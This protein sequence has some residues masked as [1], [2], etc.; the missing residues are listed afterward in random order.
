MSPTLDICGWAH[1][2]PIHSSNI[3][4]T[5]LPAGPDDTDLKLA[6]GVGVGLT[7]AD[8][9]SVCGV[10]EG[11]YY[12]R[13]D[14]R[15]EFFDTWRAFAS[16]LRNRALAAEVAKLKA[17]QKAE[18]KIISRLDAALKITDKI[19]EQL[20]GEDNAG[21]CHECDRITPETMKELLA[22]HKAITQWVGKFAASEAPRRIAMEG[23]VQHTHRVVGDETIQRL[24]AFMQQNTALLPP[25]DAVEAEVVQ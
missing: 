3:G 1:V 12:N 19:I 15:P 13:V 20:T 2:A 25:A 21:R 23:N 8:A 11:T 9:T 22:A 5:Y 4:D 14:K 18:D 17:G 6:L 10:S 16:L 24:T 7:I